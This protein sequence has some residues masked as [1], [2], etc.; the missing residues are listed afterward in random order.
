VL[1]AFRR[2]SSQYNGTSFT[3]AEFSGMP[4]ATRVAVVALRKLPSEMVFRAA[5]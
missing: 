2:Q 5:A 3:Y 1:Y 4:M